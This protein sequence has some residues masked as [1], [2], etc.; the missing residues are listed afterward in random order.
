MSDDFFSKYTRPGTSTSDGDAIQGLDGGTAFMLD[1]HFRSG[2]RRAFDYSFLVSVL[3]DPSVGVTLEFTSHMVTI[4]GRNLEGLYKR[5]LSHTATRISEAT[6][7]FDATDGSDDD[8]PYVA[9]IEIA[10][11]T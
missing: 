9:G 3:F 7:A 2:N 10:E 4:T 11:R 5:L 6:S 8:K 1:L